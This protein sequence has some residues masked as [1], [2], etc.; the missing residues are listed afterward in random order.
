MP[1]APTAEDIVE[2]LNE[3]YQ[4]TT[5]RTNNTG[6]A[7]QINTTTIVATEGTF[8]YEIETQHN[9]FYKALSVVTIPAS[10]NDPE[11]PLEF[12]E[13]EHI[14]EEWSWVTETGG[15]LYGSSSHAGR[16]IAFYR[17]MGTDGETI[18][19]EIRPVPTQDENYKITYQVGNYWDRV[20]DTDYELPHKEYKFHLRRL[21][22][23]TLLH[24]TRWSYDAAAN[25]QRKQEV[26]ATLDRAIEMGAKAFDD[27]IASLDQA[28]IVEMETYGDKFYY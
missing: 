23:S 11:Y 17:K 24:K 10:E 12:V 3:V 18:W 20:V 19:C 25:Q 14:P 26:A 16:Y 8:V 4:W 5:N 22:A 15:Q 7:W 9:D 1:N 28:N 27:H 2:A 13:V 6:N 21:A